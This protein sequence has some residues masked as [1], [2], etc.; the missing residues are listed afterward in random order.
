MAEL[1]TVHVFMVVSCSDKAF[2]EV[3]VECVAVLVFEAFQALFVEVDLL[4]LLD[5][6]DDR[7]VS[8]D[9]REEAT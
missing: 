2:L 7:S 8:E 5:L 1:R 3:K 6:V 4:D 9:D